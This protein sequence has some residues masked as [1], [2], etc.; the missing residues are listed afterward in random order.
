MQGALT[1]P[2]EGV[3]EVEAAHHAGERVVSRAGLDPPLHRGHLH[4]GGARLLRQL[5]VGLLHLARWGG[6]AGERGSGAPHPTH[7]HTHTQGGVERGG[8]GEARSRPRSAPTLLE[9]LPGL[10][11]FL[12]D[13]LLLR[14]RRKDCRR[15]F[16]RDLTR[17]R[18]PSM[19]SESLGCS[20]HLRHRCSAPGP[21][22]R[23]PSPELIPPN[24][25]PYG[26]LASTGLR[27]W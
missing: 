14:M 4:L 21:L 5:R 7:T 19:A 20:V 6:G 10:S 8:N 18:G 23:V 1:V 9:G 13:T 22:C 2:Q 17:D 16:F 24:N 3:G 12:P 15:D 27:R 26:Y 11:L 25:T